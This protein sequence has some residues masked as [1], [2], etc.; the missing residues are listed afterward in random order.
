MDS[1]LGESSS[2]QEDGTL[3]SNDEQARSKQPKRAA[4][5]KSKKSPKA[6]RSL[7]EIQAE[8]KTKKQLQCLPPN[9]SPRQTTQSRMA[10]T[11]SHSGSSQDVISAPHGDA[12]DD[13][14]MLF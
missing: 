7:V 1:D 9:S 8:Y 2:E 12:W 14:V 11:P 13:V 4:Q 6:T 5:H 10:T 3:S